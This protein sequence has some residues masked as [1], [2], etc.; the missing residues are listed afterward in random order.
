LGVS[1]K[2]QNEGSILIQLRGAIM[3]ALLLVAFVPQAW[4]SQERPKNHDPKWLSD[5]R[6]GILAHDVPIWSRSRSEGGVGFNTEFIFVWPNYELWAGMVHSNL[7]ITL[8]SQGDTSKIYSGFL[9]E[10][11]WPSGMFLNLGLGLAVHDGKL[12]TNDN[13]RKE[14]GSR[15]LFRIPVEIGFLFTEHHGLSIMF[16][17][18]SNAYVAEPNEGLDNIGIRYTYRF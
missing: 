10:Y 11:L 1:F 9:W 15:I 5:I 8:N 6:V 7:G 16:D 14:L 3:T 4:C 17:H 18:V 12:E 2:N 13:N